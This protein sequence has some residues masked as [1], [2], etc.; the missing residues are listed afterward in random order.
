MFCLKLFFAQQWQIGRSNHSTVTEF[1]HPS[2][3]LKTHH[4]VKVVNKLMTIG[5]GSIEQVIGVVVELVCI[6]A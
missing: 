4:F 5:L 6:P 3:V 1:E 2:L